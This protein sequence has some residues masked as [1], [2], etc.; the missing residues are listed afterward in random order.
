LSQHRL[1]RSVRQATTSVGHATSF[2]RAL[3]TSP[4]LSTLQQY[5]ESL[6]FVHEYISTNAVSVHAPIFDDSTAPGSSYNNAS[7]LTEAAKIRAETSGTVDEIIVVF[8]PH[9]SVNQDEISQNFCAQHFADQANSY[10]IVTMP[11]MPDRG[12]SCGA[13]F[14]SGVLDGV[15]I[16]LGHEVAESI[17]DPFS[18]NG[19]N[20][21][22]GEIGD[23]CAWQ[24]LM[25]N[26]TESGL[27][28]TQPL[29][30]NRA[31]NCIQMT[32]AMQTLNSN[33]VT[34]ANGGGL[35][36]DNTPLQTNRTVASTWETFGL[37]WDNRWSGTFYIQTL[38]GRYVTAV[39]G[40]GIGGPNNAQSPIHTDATVLG[41]WEQFEFEPTLCQGS[42]APVVP[43]V[44]MTIQASNGDFV[45]AQGG[46]DVGGPNT[47]P[48]H[49]DAMAPQTW[50]TFHFVAPSSVL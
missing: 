31:G 36:G 23:L 28:V 38:D 13:N 44:C 34:A 2:M 32:A 10:A 4:W 14:V 9:G 8:T 15:T 50:E 25:D 5:Y 47:M 1:Y 11:Y 49:T 21:P 12:G 18:G 20:S 26:Y 41:P 48:I 3:S 43:N 17:T 37:I 19:W 46:G 45:T 7:V 33:Y 22:Q 30:S 27:F 42:L 29:W 6:F 16:V 39:N 35:G 24:E 40:G